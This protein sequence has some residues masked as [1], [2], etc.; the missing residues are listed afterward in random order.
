ML[1]LGRLWLMP[2]ETTYPLNA[3]HRSQDA[4]T[5]ALLTHPS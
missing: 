2:S 3:I 5:V 4:D 1:K